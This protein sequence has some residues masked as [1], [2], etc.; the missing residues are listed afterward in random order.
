[1]L[2]GGGDPFLASSPKKADVG[3]PNRT[4]VQTLARLTVRKLRT[5][6][7]RRVRL[8]FD[9]SYFSGPAV[10]P[11]WPASYIPEDVVPPISSLWVDQGQ[12][13]DRLRVSSPTLPR[14]RPRCS[15]LPCSATG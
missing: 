1:M 4:D 9:D 6:K 7:V 15:A 8:A 14:R 13:P 10:N 12:D 5:M 3:Y 11:A 2:V